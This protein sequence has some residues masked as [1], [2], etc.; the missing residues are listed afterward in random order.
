MAYVH[1]RC[2]VALQ[3]AGYGSACDGSDGTEVM[4]PAAAAQAAEGAR[5]AGGEA[6]YVTLTLRPAGDDR[7]ASVYK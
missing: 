2:V 6:C 7:L 1:I 3:A 4:A 5:A